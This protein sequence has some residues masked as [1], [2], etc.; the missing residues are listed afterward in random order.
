LRHQ[1]VVLTTA[2]LE[3]DLFSE[4]TI[5]DG[6]KSLSC[7]LERPVQFSQAPELFCLDFFKDFDLDRLQAMIRGV[8]VEFKSLGEPAK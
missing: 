1:V 5:R 7:L 6:V 8:Q 3:P 2:A 4:I